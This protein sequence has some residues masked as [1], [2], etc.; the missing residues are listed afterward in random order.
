MS[1]PA[2]QV[3]YSGKSVA[4]FCELLRL[5]CKIASPMARGVN[6]F[7]AF[8]FEFV[9]KPEEG[10][11]AVLDLP[12]AIESALEDFAGFAGTLVMVS[13]SEARMLTVFIFWQGSEARRSCAQSV[14]RARGLLAPYL[15][16]CL[17]AQNLL[18]CLPAPQALSIRFSSIDTSL[19][20]GDSMAQAELACVA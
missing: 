10:A 16:R 2:R 19:I 20:T 1:T 4:A 11:S 6:P 18:A 9:A 14:R 3:N 12:A 8:S 13:A 5:Q 15:D 7:T 17:R